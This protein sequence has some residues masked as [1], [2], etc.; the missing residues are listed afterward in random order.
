MDF[1]GHLV[2]HLPLVHVDIEKPDH[3]CTIHTN[4]YS[5]NLV[6]EAEA[7]IVEFFSGLLSNPINIHKQKIP[8]IKVY[9]IQT[10]MKN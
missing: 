2:H 3:L 9:N 10:S 6:E 5:F 7:I 1:R 4:F 8:D